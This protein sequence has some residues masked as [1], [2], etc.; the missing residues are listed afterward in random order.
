MTESVTIRN[1][2]PLIFYTMLYDPLWV[3]RPYHSFGCHLDSRQPHAKLQCLYGN[4]ILNNF[5]KTAVNS[6]QNI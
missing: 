1:V 5:C 2:I 6:D 4:L 3:Y